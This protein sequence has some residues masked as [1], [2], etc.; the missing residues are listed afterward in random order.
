MAQIVMFVRYDIYMSTDLI[1][2]ARGKCLVHNINKKNTATHTFT[3][4]KRQT[5]YFFRVGVVDLFI[6][7]SLSEITK[8]Y[9]P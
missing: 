8:C 2:L 4:L 3:S 6:N 7:S 5:D 9:L 1:D